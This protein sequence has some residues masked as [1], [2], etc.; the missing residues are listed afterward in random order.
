M[1]KWTF[2]I[3]VTLMILSNLRVTTGAEPIKV[4]IDE[5]RVELED[6]DYFINERGYPRDSDWRCSF[7][8]YDQPWGFGTAAK[9]LQSVASIDVK[10]SGTL[11]YSKLR[12]YDVLI[13]ASFTESYSSS[14]VEAIKQF[15]GNGGGLLFLADFESPNN[16]VARTFD[17]LFYSKTGAIA[18]NKAK[19][20]G[21]DT[22]QFYIDDIKSHVVTKG[23]DQIV[24]N[25]GVP[26]VS[27]ESGKSL[28]V[29]S[30][31]S[32]FDLY[33]LKGSGAM[34]DDED[35][36]SFDVL[37]VM[38]TASKGRAVFFGCSASFYN[39]V[40]DEEDQQNLD[41]LENA[42]KWLGEPGGPHKQYK[43]MNEQ[44]QQKLSDATSL[45]MGHQF[46]QAIPVFEEAVNIFEES[47]EIYANSEAADGI[48][49]A[50]SYIEKCETGI[51]ADRI[52]DSAKAL[53]DKRE[54]ENAIK[55]FE[56]AKS[57][58]EEIEYTAKIQECATKVEE[59]NARIALREKATQ[60][61]SDAEAALTIAPSTFN[62]S[63]YES[64]KVLFQ[65]AKSTWQEYDDSEKVTTC[66]EKI[67]QCN[68]EIA[69]IE[70][71][72]LIVIIGAV[73]VVVVLVVVVV[74]VKRKGKTKEEESVVPPPAAEGEEALVTLAERYIKGE[75]TKEEYKEL[76]SVLEKG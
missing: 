53:Y 73:V 19:Q 37:V 70:R 29:T 3:F 13:L 14:E 5:S 76:K 33:R 22:N 28:A 26:I 63:G 54:Y 35:P 1:K 43:M 61:L 23:V 30:E 51:E 49:Q 68:D 56:Q 44:A 31:D 21:P 16:S 36:G 38:E 69:S 47:K 59:S 32:W 6:K 11:S 67:D 9:R 8:N 34:D 60:E 18:D 41:L 52:F 58:Y 39:W 42:V 71:T 25:F 17:V 24:Y 27:F 4:L 46:S 15:V 65:K 40:V 50:E 74:V 12:N 57:L 20:L 55:N 72:R 10:K 66:Q 75:I 2:C 64:A 48:A 7:E 45:F 62:P